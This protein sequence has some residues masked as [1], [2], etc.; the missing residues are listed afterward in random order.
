MI[1]SVPKLGERHT[2]RIGR[3]V[4]MLHHHYTGELDVAS[5]CIGDLSLSVLRYSPSQWFTF[6]RGDEA[7]AYF[8][9]LCD[10][11]L[12]DAMPVPTNPSD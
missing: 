5:L 2:E 11:A 10:A 12:L 7:V 9:L 8:N 4:V 1:T 3:W 6:D